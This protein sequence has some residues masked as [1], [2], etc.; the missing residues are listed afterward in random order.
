MKIIDAIISHTPITCFGK[1]EVRVMLEGG[2][3]WILL[4]SYYSDE[5]SF[6]KEEFIGLT[7]DEG[8]ALFTKKDI[9][10]LQS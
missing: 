5:L 6:N 3:E 8:H 2:D 1:S 7:E 10:Y 4:F 9:A